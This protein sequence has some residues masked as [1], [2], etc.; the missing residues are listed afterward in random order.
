MC[1]LIAMG[2]GIEARVRLAERI[3]RTKEAALISSL[4]FDIMI[5]ALAYALTWSGDVGRGVPFIMAL[6]LSGHALDLI[7][8]IIALVNDRSSAF[9]HVG[10]GV[11]AVACDGSCGFYRVFEAVRCNN[12]RVSSCMFIDSGGVYT[13]FV[14]AF[15]VCVLVLMSVSNIFLARSKTRA[16]AHYDDCVAEL[17]RETRVGGVGG[18][19]DVAAGGSRAVMPSAAR[20]TTSS[21][22]DVSVSGAGARARG[23]DARGGLSFDGL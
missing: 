22:Y 9:V 6:V 2:I 3:A 21:L 4:I 13:D 16:R 15:F 19:A 12:G 11:I 7:S 17:V 20:S 10:L 14:G 1:V 23:I 18:G 5:S 8:V